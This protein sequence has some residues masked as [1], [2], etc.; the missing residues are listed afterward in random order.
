MQEKR[1]ALLPRNDPETAT[2]AELL[3]T[4]HRCSIVMKM[5]TASKLYM[6]ICGDGRRVE[7]PA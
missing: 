4:R 1:V 3:V 7:M 2:A 5:E 6:Y